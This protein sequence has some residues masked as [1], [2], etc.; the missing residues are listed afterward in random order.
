[1][2][3]SVVKPVDFGDFVGAIKELGLFRAAINQPAPAV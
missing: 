1:V 3:A 2:N